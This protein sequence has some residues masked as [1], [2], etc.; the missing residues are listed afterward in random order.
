MNYLKL[1]IIG[2]L[3]LAVLGF[4]NNALA[5]KNK[6]A[7]QQ[8]KVLSVSDEIQWISL[9]EL[10]QKLKKEP[11]MILFDFYTTWC[12]WCKVMD[13]KTYSNKQLAKYI[14]KNYYAVKFNAESKEA[15]EFRGKQFEFKPEYKAH[16]FAVELMNG[17]MS[18]PSTVFVAPDFKMINPVAGYLRIDQMEGIV[19]YFIEAYPKNT[20]WNDF[21]KNFKA[22]WQ[23]EATAE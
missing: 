10:E 18:Y 2:L 1:I 15:L 16:T 7:T 21:Q 12:G 14:N 8:T 23:Q 22:E 9:S 5:Q 3:A 17:Q 13:K 19:K 20:D 11:R 4:S 6:K